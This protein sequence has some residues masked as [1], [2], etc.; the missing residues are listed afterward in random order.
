M[1]TRTLLIG[2]KRI[3]LVSAIEEDDRLYKEN[4]ILSLPTRVYLEL[5][6]LLAEADY[7]MASHGQCSDLSTVYRSVVKLAAPY[8]IDEEG[9]QRLFRK[10]QRDS[11]LQVDNDPDTKPATLS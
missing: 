3:L 9:R 6:S 7:L 10:C 4:F 5:E 1:I 2:T 8:A 11:V